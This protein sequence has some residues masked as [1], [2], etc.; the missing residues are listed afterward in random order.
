MKSD[1][2]KMLIDDEIRAA[3]Y[4]RIAELFHVDQSLIEDGWVFGRDLI[5]SFVSD[6]KYNELDIL[7]DDFLYAANKNIRKRINRGEFLICSVG[8]FWRYMVECYKESP[9]RVHDVLNLPK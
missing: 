8:G 5:P 4:L 3:V 2:G 9:G 1:G 7:H 6:F